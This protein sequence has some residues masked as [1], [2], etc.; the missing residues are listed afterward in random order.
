[1]LP[2]VSNFVYEP[3]HQ[4]E[5]AQRTLIVKITVFWKS[6]LGP[7]RASPATPGPVLSIPDGSGVNIQSIC[8]DFGRLSM[9]TWPGATPL[10]G[11]HPGAGSSGRAK[12]KQN[13]E[14]P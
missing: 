1:M 13:H 3:G 9:F 7:A 14:N 11:M 2:A 4:A 6:A 5:L 10:I 12:I 8:I